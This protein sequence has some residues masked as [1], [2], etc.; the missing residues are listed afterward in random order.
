ML[1]IKRKVIVL[2]YIYDENWVGGAYYIQNL[3]IA[4]NK[5][6]DENKPILYLESTSEDYNNF[7]KVTKY[8]YINHR[9]KLLSPK[10]SLIERILNK[11]SRIANKRNVIVKTGYDL[12]FPVFEL[13]LAASFKSKLIWIPDFQEHYFPDLFSGEE[14]ERRKKVQQIISN[15]RA[16]LLLSSKSALSD[17]QKLYPQAKSKNYVV[18]FAVSHPKFR[19]LDICKLKDKFKV[20]SD[21]FISCNQFWAHKNHL[22]IIRAV[23][24]LKSEGLNPCVVLTGKQHDWR[25]PGYFTELTRLVA[26]YN[27]SDNVLFLGLIDRSEQLQLMSHSIAIIQPSKFE[28]WSTVIEDAKAMNQMVIASNLS[29]HREQLKENCTF[30]EPDSAEELALVLKKYLNE[31]PIRKVTDYNINVLKYASDFLKIIKN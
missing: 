27:L 9:S 20:K 16:K 25:N 21:Y 30:F 18:P 4:F 12:L 28:G 10:Y 7:I 26:E 23:K 5:L 22:V 19:D 31:R 11:I 6:T 13:N 17:Y 3:A 8:P 29:V 14:I 24:L 15:S 1:R 2:C